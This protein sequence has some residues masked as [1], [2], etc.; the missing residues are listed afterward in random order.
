M[1]E[2]P[3]YPLSFEP[4][5]RPMPWGG[6]RLE[7]WVNKPLPPG[8][9]IG[10]AWLLSDHRLHT[11]KISNG[12]LA[13]VTLHDVLAK[14]PNEL[15]GHPAERFPL[16]IKLLDAQDNLSVQVHPSDATAKHL[17]PKEGGKTEAW[18]VL[19]RTGSATIYLGLKRGVGRN[20]LQREIAAGR[21]PNCLQQFHPAEHDCYFVPAG[22]V[23]ALGGGLVILEVQQTSDATFRIYDWG[24]VEPAGKAR[25]LHIEDALA[26]LDE[27]G[28][29]AGA[30]RPAHT[31]LPMERL[32]ECEHFYLGWRR[33][34]GPVT[35]NGLHMVFVVAGNCT[36]TAGAETLLLR[37]GS[38][39]L[40]PRSVS[41]GVL[42]PE[43]ACRL[44]EITLP[45][46]DRT[47]R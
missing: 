38:F 42:T 40:I 6:R 19:E 3:L 41:G 2:N 46:K 26:A 11:S 24:R 17:A 12:P 18:V 33:M 1:S 34:S 16:L 25:P 45:Q 13:G 10:E 32:V 8:G 21:V 44:L 5:L 37:P 15:L 23:H 31:E 9:K 35:L 20:T 29:A 4:F 7:R 30:R 28:A 47:R 39:V 43:G 22:T 36:L 14:R 27:H